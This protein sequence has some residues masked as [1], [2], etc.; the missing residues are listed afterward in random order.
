MKVI[1]IGG[2][3]SGFAAAI[4]AKR[5]NHDVT[6]LEKNPQFLKKLKITGN[7]RCNYYND[8][9]SLYHYNSQN[10]ELISRIINDKN[11]EKISTFFDSLGIIPK[12]SNGYYY[13]FSNQA[14]SICSSL[15]LEAKSLG[16]ILKEEVEV[17][18]I[19][20][21]EKFKVITTKGIYEADKII[22][23]TGGKSYEKTGSNG[24]GYQELK[25]LGHNIN[26]LLPGLTP[27]IISDPKK[28]WKGVRTEA[29]LKLLEDNK[30][31]REE[32]GEVQLAE[33]G[34]SGICTM[35]LSSA[36]SKGLYL[37]KTESIEINF[38]P[39]L[40][41]DFI[42]FMDDRAKLMKNRT[43]IE[44]LEGILNYKLIKT[45]LKQEENLTWNE[46]TS[47]EKETIKN[48][49]LSYVVQVKNTKSFDHAQIT[50]GGVSLLD[51]NLETMESS[52]IKGLYI[53]GELLDLSG[54]CGGYNLTIAWI[55]GIK[56]GESL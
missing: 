33:D 38:M 53:A 36:I 54:D 8:D 4:T 45:L 41:E 29:S 32:K 37:D 55:T 44:L 2:G 17:K 40:Q 47:K 15:I 51:I 24:F 23:A 14:I 34:I 22:I 21:E 30:V 27:L 18:K 3:A 10:N 46:C 11:L 19:E 25:R 12:I 56:A 49:L 43:I 28:D 16:V 48:K 13:P 7:G 42:K 26:P 1:I 6:I 52:K 31:I 20:K 5:K 9:Q 39:F 35:Q 50:L